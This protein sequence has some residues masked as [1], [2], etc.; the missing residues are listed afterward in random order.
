MATS[1]SYRYTLIGKKVHIFSAFLADRGKCAYLNCENNCEKRFKAQTQAGVKPSSS[2]MKSLR[3]VLGQLEDRYILQERK[4]F[5][6]LCLFWPE[7]VGEIVAAQ[8]RPVAIRQGVLQVATSSA[9][10]AQNLVF[11]RRRILEKLNH[12]LLL[13]LVDI[14]FS[15]SQWHTLPL[16][17]LNTYGADLEQVWQNHPSRLPTERSLP[18][19]PG[20][21]SHSSAL[22]NY[23]R[24]ATKVQLSRQH[25]PLCPACQAPTPPE[26]LARWSICAHCAAKQW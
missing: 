18:Q 3:H 17:V 12:Q 23:Q 9:A 26:E 8:T 10:W 16:P 2:T 6:K 5:Q 13:Q 15:T 20:Q 11:E 24:W 19:V 25:L 4:Q 14:R 22:Q 21:S 7:I 1:L